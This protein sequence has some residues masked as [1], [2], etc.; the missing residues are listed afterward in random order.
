VLPS[1]ADLC[2]L[3][4]GYDASGGDPLAGEVLGTNAD[5]V[6]AVLGEPTHRLSDTAWTYE[7]CIGD[8]SRKASFTLTFAK[9]DRCYVDTGKA[10]TPPYWMSD[11][12]V[13]GMAMPACWMVGA[14]MA[15]RCPECLDAK[16]VG[17][18][19]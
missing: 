16:T 5:D 7:W 4:V 11:V 10:V 15:G 8:C 6:R 13:D 12:K 14:E 17:A 1:Q 3:N 18:C 2:K 9:L 19:E